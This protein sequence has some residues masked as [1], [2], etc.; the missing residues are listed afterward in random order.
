MVAVHGRKRHGGEVHFVVRQPDGTLMLLPA[1]MT[2]PSAESY[3][4]ISD[5]Q[6]P[7]NLKVS[8]RPPSTQMRLALAAAAQ[9]PD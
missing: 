1:W 6:L 4:L 3:R 5:P 7:V 9:K 2:E 8:A